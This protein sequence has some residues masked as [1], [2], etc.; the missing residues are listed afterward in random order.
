MSKTQFHIT[1]AAAFAIERQNPWQS[2]AEIPP[3]FAPAKERYL[4]QNLCQWLRKTKSRHSQVILGPRRVGKTVALYQTVRN[5]LA[6]N[7]HPSRIY[8]LRLDDPDLQTDTLGNLARY[9]IQ[10]SGATTTAPAYLMLDEVVLMDKWAQWLKSFHDDNWPLRVVA[11]SSARTGLK[12]GQTESVDRWREQHLLPCGLAE[13]LKLLGE[14]TE[15]IDQIPAGQ[16]FRETINSVHRLGPPDTE[17]EAHRNMLLQMGGFPGVLTSFP[18]PEQAALFGVSEK[19][20]F[21]H[22]HQIQLYENVVQKS[23]Y[24]DIPKYFNITDPSSLENILYRAARQMGNIWEPGNVSTDLGVPLTTLKIY[25]KHL[26][27]ASIILMLQNFPGGES[28]S[29]NRGRKIYFTDTALRNA[30]LRYKGT[31][32][33]DP[34]DYGHMLENMVASAL[35]TLAEQTRFRLY[36]W[37]LGKAGDRE[38]DVIYNDI[39]DPMAFEVGSSSNHSLRGL[40]ALIDKHPQFHG[41]SYLVAPNAAFKPAEFSKT[42]IGSVSLDSLLLAA[43][44]HAAH[45]LKQRFA[46]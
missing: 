16:T 21:P 25:T 3:E 30:V 38:V 19:G 4:V 43:D 46:I 17:L 41:G 13:S 8:F 44:I 18:Q 36:H 22:L 6:D 1:Q 7:V 14:M 28:R 11:T 12:L 23:I 15:E 24:I 37:R 29:Q 32:E 26:E 2:G 35:F 31:R 42:G 40:K 33:H 20:Y 39:N 45:T 27:M 10:V 9:I 5:L 34:T